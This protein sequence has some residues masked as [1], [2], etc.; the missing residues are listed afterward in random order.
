MTDVAEIKRLLQDIDNMQ[1]FN[2]GQITAL[3]VGFFTL[4]RHLRSDAA[5]AA[6]M[7]KELDAFRLLLGKELGDRHPEVAGYDSAHRD[8]LAG[9]RGEPRPV[10][11]TSPAEKLHQSTSKPH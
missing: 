1:N 7:E 9:I 5:F 2:A 4:L 11:E 3:R 6:T 10:P 8:L